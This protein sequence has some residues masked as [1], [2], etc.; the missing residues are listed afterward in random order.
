M[1]SAGG[2]RQLSAWSDAEFGPLEMTA[3][4]WRTQQTL[5]EQMGE[6]K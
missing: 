4:I 5:S 3:G 1:R 6:Q 2:L